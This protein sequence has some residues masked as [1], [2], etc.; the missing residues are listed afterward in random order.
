M[1]ISQVRL[2]RHL[3]KSRRLRNPLFDA[4]LSSFRRFRPQRK[5][6]RDLR[7]KEDLCAILLANL[8]EE[9][10][11]IRADK[12]RRQFLKQAGFGTVAATVGVASEVTSSSADASVSEKRASIQ[13]L[14]CGL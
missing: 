8:V 4:R 14:S 9:W 2:L 7:P 11:R 12:L 5:M 6:R 3:Q 10:P 13:D 1:V